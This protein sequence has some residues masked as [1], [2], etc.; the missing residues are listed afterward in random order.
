MLKVDHV[1]N[2][3]LLLLPYVSTDSVLSII[4]LIDLQ[5]GT[6]LYIIM[7]EQLVFAILMP[8]LLFIFHR[9]ANDSLVHES[10][11]LLQDQQRDRN[12]VYVWAIG[13]LP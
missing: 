3:R 12:E 9:A 13:R 10:G 2:V 1:W 11:Y 6:Q 4:G 5:W 7:I 8:I